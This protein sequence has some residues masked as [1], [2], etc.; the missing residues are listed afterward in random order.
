[1]E[2]FILLCVFREICLH[3]LFSVRLEFSRRLTH[4]RRR[5]ITDASSSMIVVANLSLKVCVV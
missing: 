3:R 4:N 2:R 5:P 1:M